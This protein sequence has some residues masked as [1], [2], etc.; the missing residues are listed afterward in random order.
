MNHVRSAILI[1]FLHI[2]FLCQK[3][4]FETVDN[5]PWKMFFKM[6]G[7]RIE[8]R[9]RKSSLQPRQVCSCLQT[10]SHTLLNCPIHTKYKKNAIEVQK[11]T[12]S[13]NHLTTSSIHSHHP[14]FWVSQSL[15]HLR[16]RGCTSL[17]KLQVWEVLC[18]ALRLDNI[19]HRWGNYVKYTWKSKQFYP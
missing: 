12:E 15:L 7:R 17:P 16:E 19:R 10:H 14:L 18:T 2:Q 11:N 4:S 9:Q 13:K 3:C 8:R 1:I 6:F 5:C